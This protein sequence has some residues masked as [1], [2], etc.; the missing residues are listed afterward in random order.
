MFDVLPIT[1][2]HATVCGPT[3]LKML[4]NYYGIDV[5]MEELIAECGVGVTGVTASVLLR[6]GRA[7]GLDMKSYRE[8][9]Q[10]AMMQDR[11]AILWWRYTHFV[12]YCGLNEQGEPVICNPSSGRFPI[13]RDAFSR[14]FSE[15][16]LTNGET[17][18][19]VPRAK[20]NRE[21]GAVFTQDTATYRALR[22]IARG[23][24]LIPGANCETVNLID[25]L[26][27]Q[28]KESEG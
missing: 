4:L 9:A 13:S 5:P 1:T 3:C 14:F 7:H 11:P 26:N 22:P 21:A 12:V 6:V 24:K 18:D 17:A 10:D 19:Y 25:L 8:S 23:E 2:D 15:I 27:E 20:E 28:K 16:A